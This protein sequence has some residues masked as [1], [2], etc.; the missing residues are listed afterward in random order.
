[1]LLEVHMNHGQNLPIWIGTQVYVF[2]PG[3]LCILI[4]MYKYL[5]IKDHGR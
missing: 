4:K 2:R 1:M 3:H 5:F